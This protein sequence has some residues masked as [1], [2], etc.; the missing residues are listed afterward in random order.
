MK[1]LIVEP[2]KT[3]QLL[4]EELLYGVSIAVVKA[5]SAKEALSVADGEEFDLICLARHLPDADGL[6][7]CEKLKYAGAN[8]HTPVFMLT[9]KRDDELV[10]AARAAGIREVFEKTSVPELKVL[11]ANLTKSERLVDRIK[12]KVLYVEDQQS[13]ANMTQDILEN[14]GLTVEHFTHADP[15]FTTLNS[16]GCDLVLLDMV[17]PGNMDGFALIR[18][19]RG[20][21]NGNSLIPILTLSARPDITQRVDALKMGANDFVTKPVLSAELEVRVR[22]LIK[23]KQLYDEVERQRQRLEK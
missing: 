22:N 16:E 12:G 17:L 7:L 19:I 23:A 2:S 4:L 1:A 5:H 3:Y 10:T 8:K 13:V 9:S 15:A 20:L 14:M 18:A 11:F 6:E 21:D